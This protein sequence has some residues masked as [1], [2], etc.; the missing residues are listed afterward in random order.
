MKNKHLEYYMDSKIF[1]ENEVQKSIDNT[2]KEFPNKEIEVQVSLNKFGV[3]VI[4][5]TFKNKNNFIKNIFIKL[6]MKK[7]SKLLL[8][9]ES[10][11]KSDNKADVRCNI[12]DMAGNVYEWSTETC[13]NG[14]GV[15]SS[16]IV[17]GDC[18]DSSTNYAA[19]RAKVLHG[20]NVY[21]A[22]RSILYL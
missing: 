10:I 13:I 5:L 15:V 7:K 8:T 17:R 19:M 20:Q 3:Y 21:V 16:D 12:Y 18:Y 9:G 14:A 2:R 1:S 22:F 11:L 4:T 6:K